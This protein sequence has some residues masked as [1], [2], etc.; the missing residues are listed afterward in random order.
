MA[1]PSAR[2][3]ARHT[4]KVNRKARRRALRSALSVHAQRGTLAVLEDGAFDGPATK[5]AAEALAKWGSKSPTL[6]VLD[7]EEAD[8]QKSFRNI[9]RVVVIPASAVGVADL[10]GAASVVVSEPAVE[11]L[12]D[13]A[14]EIAEGPR[15]GGRFL[16]DVRQVVIEPV[17]SE[18]SYALMSEGKYTFRV[19]D[20]AHKTQIS[21]AVEEIFGVRVAAVR[22]AKVRAKPKRRGIHQGHHPLLEEGHRP[23]RPGRADRAVRRGCNRVTMAI[24]KTKP[25]SP[26]RRF[27][28]YQLREEVTETKP[29]KA[30]TKGASKSGGRNSYGRVTSRHRGGGAKRRYREI[31]FKRRKDGIAAKVATIEYDPNRTTY[32]ALLHY[33]DGEKRYILAPAGVRPGDSSSP[34]RR[35]TSG[36]ATRCRCGRSRPAPSSTTSSSSPARAAASAAPPAPRSRWSRRR[37]RW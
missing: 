27:A 29:N 36:P 28:T 6:V 31:D 37:A 25:T 5:Q 32:I 13:R 17:I 22:T 20:R 11:V 26:G 19:A 18:K 12:K 9:P 8:A 3:R 14:G 2:S 23:A 15:A 1:S 35:P 10:L 4:V 16:M 7:A 21:H 30:L 33:V 24:R 34:A